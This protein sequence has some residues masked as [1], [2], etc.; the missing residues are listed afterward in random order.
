MELLNA[1]LRRL[2]LRIAAACT[3]VVPTAAILLRPEAAAAHVKWFTPTDVHTAPVPL[4][5]V[6]SPTF[7][8][9]S[10]LFIILLLLGFLLDGW[11]AQAWPARLG[12][13]LRHATTEQRLV[14]AAAG[15]YFICASAAG[16]MILTPELATRSSWIATTQFAIAFFLVWRRTCILSGLGVLVLYLDA[17]RIYGAFHLVD[18]LFLPS[19]VIYLVS[20]S[21][22]SARL[23]RLREPLLVS[24]L[25]F[26]LAW[27]A[28]EKFLYPQW[29]IAVIATHP[30]I[31]LGLPVTL[32]TV[33][34][35]FVEFTL[36]FYLVTGRGL[37]RVG[38]AAYAMIFLAAMPAFGSLD[39]FGHLVI[40][41]TLTIVVLRGVTPMQERLHFAG[42]GIVFDA[43][44][45]GMLYLLTLTM[46]FAAY[47]AMQRT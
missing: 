36:A 28:I 16:R 31:A 13:G 46:F 17:M 42:R 37:L 8:S 27:T 1:R 41:A 43:A 26:S 7:L 25:A 19:L 5:A 24:G 22:N 39:V 20:L 38:G 21:L 32:V 9:V 15:A 18:Y 10:V 40:L 6:L 29:T 14:R 35:G 12:S 23:A 11:I 45:M 44:W 33:I 34:A 3:G 2:R 30:S 47:Y 4:A